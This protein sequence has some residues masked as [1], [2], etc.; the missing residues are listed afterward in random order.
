MPEPKPDPCLEYA[1]PNVATRTQEVIRGLYRSRN[2][3]W[4]HDHAIVEAAGLSWGQAQTL[5]ALLRTEPD[6]CLSPTRLYDE[7]QA[8]SGGMSKMLAGLEASGDVVRV[9]NPG[10]RRSR[11]VRLT[12]PGKA[13]ITE[14]ARELGEVNTALLEEVLSADEQAQL[15]AAFQ[16]LEARLA[17]KR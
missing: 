8:S 6:H 1:F 17:A 15:A 3:L 16:R 9:D 13:R 14:L 5:I 7:V 10:D 11:L 12:E 4:E 2:L